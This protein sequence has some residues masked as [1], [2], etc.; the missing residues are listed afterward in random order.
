MYDYTKP[1]DEEEILE[2]EVEEF[3]EQEEAIVYEPQMLSSGIDM[4]GIVTTRL[5]VRAE[6]SRDSKSLAIL[7][8]GDKVII[9]DEFNDGWYYIVTV[10]GDQEGYCMSEFIELV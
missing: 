1:F 4:E 2:N 3:I 5:H 8:K 7:N 6:A 10:K 9:L